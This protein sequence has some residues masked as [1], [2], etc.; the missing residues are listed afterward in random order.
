M[1]NFLTYN[2]SEEELRPQLALYGAAFSSGMIS[3]EV[4]TER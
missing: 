3:S 1:R 2:R 4:E